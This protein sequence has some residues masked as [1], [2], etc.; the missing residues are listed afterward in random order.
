MGH[1]TEHVTDPR[2]YRLH[3]ST[4]PQGVVLAWDYPGST[5]LEV[6]IQRSEVGFAEEPYRGSG[7]DKLDDDQD[8]VYDGDTGSF[9]DRTVEPGKTYYYTVW[10]RPLPRGWRPLD[11]APEHFDPD[12]DRPPDAGGWV[13]WG[14]RKVKAGHVP[15][16]RR[17]VARLLGRI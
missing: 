2:V 17:L 8:V 12:E 1:D 7:H 16:L 5:L 10:A 3:A 6:R 11:V 13:L 14:T 15:R 9:H 4:S